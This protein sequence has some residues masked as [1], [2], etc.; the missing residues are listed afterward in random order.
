MIVDPSST[1]RFETEYAPRD[2]VQLSGHFG[3]KSLAPI[4]RD[5]GR[6]RFDNGM[7]YLMAV[8]DRLTC[9]VVCTDAPPVGPVQN[10]PNRPLARFAFCKGSASTDWSP[11]A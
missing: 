3:S 6:L 10:I 9:L 5:K 11:A 7:A 8:Q 2:M 1:G 4:E